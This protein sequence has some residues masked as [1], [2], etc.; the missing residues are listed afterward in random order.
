[1][2]EMAMLRQWALCL[3]VLVGPP[4]SSGLTLFGE[5]IYGATT[6]L[7]LLVSMPPGV[8]TWTGPELAP[9]GTTAVIYVFEATLKDAAARLLNV[10]ALVRSTSRCPN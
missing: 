8:V 6:K 10:T 2:S 9:T 3:Y 5:S 4:V 7:T 1:M